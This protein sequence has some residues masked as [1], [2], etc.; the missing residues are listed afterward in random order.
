MDHTTDKDLWDKLR[1][2]DKSALRHIYNAESDYLYNY[3]RKIFSDIQKVEDAIHDLFVEIWQKRE[4]LGPTD[5]IRR[6][7][8]A[9]LRRKVVEDLRKSARTQS[10]DDFSQVNFTAELAIEDL[11]INEEI[12][13]EKAAR[14][15][16]AFKVLSSRQKEVMY[17]KFY[18]GHDY[19]QIAE[20]TGVS[21]QS[22]RNI[23][24]ASIKKLREAMIVSLILF[25]QFI[26][27]S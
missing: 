27:R 15:N 9:S 5:S 6:Y 24:S 3:G 20:I 4:R 19:E 7:L 2:G 14:L 8:A 18:Q 13:S 1:S 17:L 12:S 16:E 25:L 26:L 23:I 22:L 21:Y 11:L 10:T